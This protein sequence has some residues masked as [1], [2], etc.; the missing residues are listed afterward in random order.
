MRFSS[1]GDT[2]IISS[3]SRRARFERLRRRWLLPWRVRRSFP[4][5]DTLNRLA[6]AWCVFSLGMNHNPA[7]VGKGQRRTADKAAHEC[8]AEEYHAPGHPVHR[9]AH[10]T[11]WGVISIN[12]TVV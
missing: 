4:E 12:S 5:P 2:D 3:Y 7:R 1:A 11:R 8:V 10:Y 6:V 9:N